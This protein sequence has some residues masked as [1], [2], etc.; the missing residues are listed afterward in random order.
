MSQSDIYELLKNKR[1]SGDHKYF[2]AEEIRKMLKDKGLACYRQN[3]NNQITTLR[4]F[5]Y[6]DVKIKATKKNRSKYIYS[7]Y[8]LKK[9][10]LST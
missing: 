3:V 6:L 9:A 10:V 5:G 2:S 1:L 4:I 8:R 7:V